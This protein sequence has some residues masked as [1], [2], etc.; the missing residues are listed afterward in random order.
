VQTVDLD[1]EAQEDWSLTFDPWTVVDVDGSGTY[2][3]E[4]VEFP[5]NYEPMAFIAFNPAT[6]IPPMTDDVEIQPHGGVRF[7][8]CMAS[9]DPTYLND[10]WLISP[11][12]ALGMNSNITLWVKSYTPQYGLERYNI[13]VSTT[14]NEPE[15]F[16]SISGN[17]Y[18]EAPEDWTEVSFDLSEYDGQMV[19][20]AIQCVT[21]DAFIFM[22][23]DISI[24]FTVGTPEQSQ[25]IDIA[26]YPNPVT[27][28]MNI[29]SG[30]EMTQVEI[31][32][33]LGQKVYG[34]VIKDT[35]FNLNT[36]EFN[37][38]VY[39]IRITTENG[40]ATE[41]VMVR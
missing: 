5:H 38:G 23:D 9:A 28:H 34:E 41:K 40:T 10:D 17:S 7:G 6:T 20:V 21:A 19:Y 3:F 8:A 32:N 15:S 16:T 18:M 14:D 36:S 11:Q 30:V 29:V 26:I 1:F 37:S 22:V 2:G 35:N 4:T 33:Q 31:F 12:I 24:S 13:L 39:Y 27:D 25:D